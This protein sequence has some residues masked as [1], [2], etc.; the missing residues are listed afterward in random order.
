ME[1]YTAK[2]AKSL[3]LVDEIGTF[4]QAV[5]MMQ[6]GEDLNDCDVIYVT[7]PADGFLAQLLGEAKAIKQS[8]S[9]L[10][11]LMELM[12]KNGQMPIAYMA[13]FPIK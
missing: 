12:A 4:D 11:M 1:S 7:P 5:S 2:Q 6:N 9:D 3:G 13:D 8:G 10:S